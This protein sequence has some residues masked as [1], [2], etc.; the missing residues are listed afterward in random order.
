MGRVLAN[1]SVSVVRTKL[2]C[3]N[4]IT[5]TR[6][7][8]LHTFVGH[9]NLQRSERRRTS[10]AKR[11][12]K[13]LSTGGVSSSRVSWPDLTTVTHGTLQVKSEGAYG[14]DMRGWTNSRDRDY[15]RVRVQPTSGGS[16]REI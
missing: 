16:R 10:A 5:G 13:G 4:D 1:R 8:E 12:Q 9:S 3:Q 2:A 6:G 14:L 7:T 15:S 11:E